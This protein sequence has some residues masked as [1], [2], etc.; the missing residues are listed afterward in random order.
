MRRLNGDEWSLEMEPAFRRVFAATDPFGQPFETAVQS[1]ALV[2]PVSYL[3]DATEFEALIDAARFVGDDML[4][5]SITETNEPLDAPTAR[6]WVLKYWEGSE[7]RHLGD[8]GVLQNAI[9]SP[10]GQWGMLLSHE[11]HGVIGGSRDFMRRFA[12]RFPAFEESVNGFLEYWNEN[13][14]RHNA[15]ISWLEPLLAHLYGIQSARELMS[16]HSE[17]EVP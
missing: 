14:R 1:R 11:Q 16:S 9:Y 4:G 10:T 17:P 15:D 7:Y 5:V 6:H 13:H 8:V 3:L 12:A 2:Y